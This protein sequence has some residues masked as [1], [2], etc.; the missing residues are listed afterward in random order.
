MDINAIITKVDICNNSHVINRSIVIILVIRLSPYHQQ[1]VYT[2]VYGF[3]ATSARSPSLVYLPP[4][5]P[6]DPH[7]GQ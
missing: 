2:G 7:T 4:H 3:W 6:N 1:Y 5:Q